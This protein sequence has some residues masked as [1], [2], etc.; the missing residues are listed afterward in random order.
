MKKGFTLIELLVSI[1]IMAIISTLVV[2]N[3]G[4]NNNQD[5]YS[6]ADNL[7]SLLRK[8]Q[9]WSISGRQFG[10]PAVPSG[11]YGVS[12]PA[13]ALPPCAV[14]MFADTDASL[15]FNSAGN[16]LGIPATNPVDEKAEAL[17]L[18]RSVKIVPPAGGADILFKPPQGIL[19][20]FNR[21]AVACPPAGGVVTIAL[22][23]QAGIDRFIDIST[24]SGQ[25]TVR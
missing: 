25:V 18:G 8:A 15:N 13:C 21:I 2:A 12:I 11:G 6:S 5:L 23:N 3:L 7:A 14:V 16:P 9:F 4:G 22:Q 20:L 10:G 24:S 17:T 19:C 1:S